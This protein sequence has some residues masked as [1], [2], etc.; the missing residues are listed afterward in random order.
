MFIATAYDLSSETWTRDSPNV[1]V[2]FVL[3]FASIVASLLS[4]LD[5]V[6]LI[7]L[8]GSEHPTIRVAGPQAVSGLREE[9]FCLT[10]QHDNES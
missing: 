2:R 3:L 9:L 6:V 7:L 4:Y 10:I 1:K 8:L 5:P